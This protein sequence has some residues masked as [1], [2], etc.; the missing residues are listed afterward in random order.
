MDWLINDA[1]KSTTGWATHMETWP[2]LRPIL[3]RL[4]E[5]RF[6]R[7]GYGSF[8][9][10]YSSFKEARES[11][12][13]NKPLGFA[14]QDY[15][16]EFADRRSK[17]FSFDYP[18]LFWLAPLLR[19]PIRLFDYGGHCGTH[20]YAYQQYV[21]YSEGLRWVVCDLPEITRCGL[22]I[23][24]E[25]QENQI[26]FTSKFDEADGADVL[27]AAGSVQYIEVPTLSVRLSG[28][29]SRPKHILLNKLPL[30][31]GP[32]FVTM[33]NGGVAFH[34]M[35]VFNRKEFIGSICWLGY[36]LVDQWAVPSH[37]GRIPFHPESSFATH[38]GLYFRLAK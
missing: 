9:G 16:Q 18:V 1:A 11:A 27:L 26:S 12:P 30:S 4:Y 34:P 14:T 2:L 7:N 31:D 25:Q 35:Y 5:R 13:R 37:P 29:K 6:A 23:A 15:A 33:Q 38:S 24:A 36:K 22:Q 21:D 32:T 20:F 8:R 17:I 28:L 3:E 19:S 10:V